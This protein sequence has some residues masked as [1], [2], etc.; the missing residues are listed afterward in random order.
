MSITDWLV[1]LND[2]EKAN[3]SCYKP[4]TIANEKAQLQGNDNVNNGKLTSA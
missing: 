3:N 2:G 1:I 4:Q